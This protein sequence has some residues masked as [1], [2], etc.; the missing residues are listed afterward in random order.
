M[1]DYFS[2]ILL[3]TLKNLNI[4]IPSIS[5]FFFFLTLSQLEKPHN[6][7]RE[8]VSSVVNLC[9]LLEF[10]KLSAEKLFSYHFLV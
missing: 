4:K 6:D 3:I 5:H 2:L 9:L 7:S 1:F 8:W 10:D